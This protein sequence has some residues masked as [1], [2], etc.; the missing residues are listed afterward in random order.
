[1][2]VARELFLQVSLVVIVNEGQ[3]PHRIDISFL[4]FILN[5]MIP[6]HVADGFGTVR[7]PLC[8][9]RSSNRSSKSSSME[10]PKRLSEIGRSLFFS[11]S[12]LIELRPNGQWKPYPFL[13][14]GS[15]R[16]TV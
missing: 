5:Q 15:S 7:I 1:M 3:R 6:D 11:I 12:L 4:K 10:T 8:A 14:L 2:L 16:D 13:E 9:Q